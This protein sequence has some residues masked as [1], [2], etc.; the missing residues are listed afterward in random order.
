MDFSWNKPH[1][2]IIFPYI[3]QSWFKSIPKGR[4]KTKEMKGTD[5]TEQ[6]LIIHISVNPLPDK[7]HSPSLLPLI[8]LLSDEIA[9]PNPQAFSSWT[10][11]RQD[12]P[13]EQISVPDFIFWCL[14]S[15][16]NST[17][18]IFCFSPKT[19]ASVPCPRARVSTEGNQSAGTGEVFR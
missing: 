8:T 2:Y 11:Q 15:S 12:F 6:P 18:R 17:Q 7:M 13:V 5:H 1:F 3:T 10:I 16:C 19:E 4:T 14:L 9:I